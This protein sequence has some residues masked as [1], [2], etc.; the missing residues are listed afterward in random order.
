VPIADGLPWF[1]NHLCFD[2]EILVKKLSFLAFA[3][4]GVTAFTSVFSS[5]KALAQTVVTD[6]DAAVPPVVYQ[7]VFNQSPTG[8]ETSSV[9]WKKANDD[10]AQFKRGHVDI[11]KWEEAQISSTGTPNSTSKPELPG[12]VRPAVPKQAAQP[13]LVAPPPMHKH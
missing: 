12:A 5:V 10:V 3:M 7:S 4:L 1:I 9:N 6:P 11:L 2:Q 8:V 13:A